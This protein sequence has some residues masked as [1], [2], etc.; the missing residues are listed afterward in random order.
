MFLAYR[1]YSIQ[2]FP[3]YH[4]VMWPRNHRVLR[5]TSEE[6][7]DVRRRFSTT[8]TTSIETIVRQRT[9]FKHV[10]GKQELRL[11]SCVSDSSCLECMR[12]RFNSQIKLAQQVHCRISEG[13]WIGMKVKLF[14]FSVVITPFSQF[15]YTSLKS[16]RKIKQFSLFFNLSLYRTSIFSVSTSAATFLVVR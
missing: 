2:W 14:D 12:I 5:K 8:V 1:C 10:T 7:D 11:V 13:P 6:L 16:P 15:E 4:S 9:G 3:E